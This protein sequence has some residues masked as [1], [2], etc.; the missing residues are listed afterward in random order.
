MEG[1]GAEPSWGGQGGA[2]LPSPTRGDRRPRRPQAHVPHVS[3]EALRHGPHGRLHAPHGLRSRGRQAL[4]VSAQRD[5]G[6]C[7]GERPVPAW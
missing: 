7:P 4:P 1:P 6:G 5:Q 3:S 2:A